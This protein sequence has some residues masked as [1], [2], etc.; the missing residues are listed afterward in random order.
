M[1]TVTR[2]NLMGLGCGFALG[3]LG[4]P[5][6]AAVVVPDGFTHEV[7][8][9]GLA[10]P[11]G[12]A[13]IPGVRRLLVV[14][15]RSARVMLVQGAAGNAPTLVG[16]VDN[17]Q[18]VQSEAGL[19]GIAVDPRWPSKPFIYVHHTAL[20][21]PGH[22]NIARYTLTGDLAGTGNGLL[23]LDPAS[24]YDLITDAPDAAGNHNGG[25]LR[26]GND[27]KLYASLGE[28]GN[29]CAAQD[30]VSLR[31]VIL[32]LEVNTLPDGPGAAARA[33]IT[34]ADN[35]FVA[36]SDPNERLVWAL[37]L[38]NPFRFLIDPQTGALDIGD[39]GQDAWEELDHATVPGM[40]FGWPW[41]EG[42]TEY[43]GCV[44]SR[45]AM[46]DPV[47]VF[48]HIEGAAI[49][50]AGVYRNPNT[51]ASLPNA[52]PAAYEG[53]SFVSDFYGGMLFHLTGL[54]ATRSIAAPV[55]GQAT[56]TYW[57]TGL[58]AVSDYL[59]GPDGALWY[60]RQAS[61]LSFP[62]NTGEIGRI[63]HPNDTVPVNA[64]HRPVVL[65]PAFPLPAANSVRLDFALSIAARV[66]IAVYDL[67]GRRVRELVK[68]ET[69]SPGTYSE[70][71]DG[72]DDH[73]RRAEAGL[74]FAKLSMAG[75]DFD[76][77]IVIAR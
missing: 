20:G 16:T 72:L 4:G 22:V 77:R 51:P 21:S 37:G 17:V 45:P 23:T 36:A 47:F 8:A 42:K 54:G 31:G 15:Q 30:R 49:M 59:I 27:G 64:P 65:R 3:V 13:F 66:S 1:N 71:W 43:S 6:T 58:E 70:T 73:G 29:A 52:F 69:R 11:V 10:Y 53:H 34:P 76:W 44:P 41:R 55:P 40:N 32:R 14:E 74:Y 56:G 18:S 9:T 57:A 38:R 2:R 19:L 62:P 35:P 48:S 46:T 33:V 68:P 39:V 67:R 75:G 26:F 12:M 25:T 63:T 7:T 61:S 28:D 50:P 24:R 5:S 60:C